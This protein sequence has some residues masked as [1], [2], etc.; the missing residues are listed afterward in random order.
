MYQKASVLQNHTYDH[1][2]ISTFC[3]SVFQLSS[4]SSHVII[5]K[6]NIFNFFCELDFV[7]Y[8]IVILCGFWGWIN[9]REFWARAHIPHTSAEARYG[10][11]IFKLWWNT[12]TA[13]SVATCVLLGFS[14][15][16]W[17]QMC[18]Q[19]TH[20]Y[21]VYVTVSS[22]AATA[23]AEAAAAKKSN[24]INGQQLSLVKRDLSTFVNCS[25]VVLL[26]VHLFFAPVAFAPYSHILFRFA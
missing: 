20:A 3:C 25:C 11:K 23:A 4:S 21:C 13:H 18:A 9:V 26:L 1:F 10:M 17:F 19:N 7:S 15:F 2:S 16:I 5:A 6:W 14:P 22:S 12:T 8:S 24:Y